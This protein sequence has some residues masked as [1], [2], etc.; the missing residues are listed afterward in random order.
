MKNTYFD[1]IDQTYYFPQEGF[2]LRDGYLTF[3][4]ISLKYLIEKYGTP[5]KLLYLPRISEQV[6][7]ARNLFNIAIR[8]NQYAGKYYYC[9]CTKCC[10][11]SHV[12]K[13]ALK[14]GV[15]LETSSSFDI[16]LIYKLLAEKE[17]DR[18]T[19]IIHNGYK[20]N[21]YLLKH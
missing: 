19:I 15:H 20:T 8:K 7:R 3:Y 16:D 14:E 6:K 12:L 5:F 21:D 1:L 13:A 11:F 18:R 17:I 9:Y 2:D 4:G 10:H